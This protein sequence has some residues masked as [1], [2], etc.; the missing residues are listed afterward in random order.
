VTRSVTR[1][2]PHDV[3]AMVSEIA[4]MM[5]NGQWVTGRS[6][7]AMAAREGVT[8]SAVERWA[9][10]AGRVLRSLTSA[11]REELQARNA[12]HL[13]A[14]AA[15]AHAAGEFGDAVRARAEMAKLLGLNAPEKH[16]HA[17][18][19]ASYEQ[20]EPKQKRAQLVEAIA[21]LQAELAELDAIDG[22]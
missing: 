1:A 17:H 11:Q 13:E 22:S 15:D 9:A 16:Q 4:G 7:Q 19:V 3:S 18:V 20:L 14:L 6:H 5:S 10:E 12:A 21:A 8:V 2:R